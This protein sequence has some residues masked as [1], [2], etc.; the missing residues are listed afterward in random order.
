MNI[1]AMTL[2]RVELDFVWQV[3]P[4]LGHGCYRAILDSVNCFAFLR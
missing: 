4:I 1:M 2:S 3:M